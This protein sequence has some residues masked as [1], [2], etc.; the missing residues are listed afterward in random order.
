MGEV[1]VVGLVGIY[2]PWNLTPIG[3]V[4]LDQDA[5]IF[6]RTHLR[7]MAF[8]TLLNP[9][10]S[11]VGAILPERVAVLA[12]GVL[13]GCM[14]EV[15]GLNL[16]GVEQIGEYDPSEKQGQYKTGEEDYSSQYPFAGIALLVVFHRESLDYSCL[17]GLTQ[18]YASKAKIDI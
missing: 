8:L 16:F 17:E 10:N 2:K 14:T 5:L 3:D 7:L 18:A 9:W 6:C 1:D 11:R 4:F 15:Y 13:V 12:G